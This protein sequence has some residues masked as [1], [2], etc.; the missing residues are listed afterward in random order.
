M[1]QEKISCHNC[2]YSINIQSGI[3]LSNNMKNKLIQ[4]GKEERGPRTLVF[5]CMRISSIGKTASEEHFKQ[6]YD[7]IIESER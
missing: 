2:K 3:V 1:G 7:S 6:I 5:L 4:L